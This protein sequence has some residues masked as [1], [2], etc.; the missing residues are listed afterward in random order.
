[1]TSDRA[2]AY[3]RVMATIESLG[4]AKLHTDEEQLIREAADSL[5]F[6]E[7]GAADPAAGAAIAEVRALA[8]K[9]VESGRWL[10]ETALRLMTDVELCGPGMDRAPVAG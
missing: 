7:D 9:L 6:C 5:L 3:G 8:A 2:Q 4:A 10:T 1:M